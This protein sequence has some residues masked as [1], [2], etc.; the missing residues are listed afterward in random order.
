M[1]AAGKKILGLSAFYHDSAAALLREGRIERAAQEE[2]FSRKKHDP[3]FPLNAIKFCLAGSGP[4][5]LRGADSP[6]T[7]FSALLRGISCIVFYEKPFLTFE[8]LLESYLRYAPRQGFAS[9]REAM[10]L[11]MGKKLNMRALIKRE[12]KKRPG[13]L[14]K[15]HP[16]DFVQLSSSFPCRLRF[17][18]QRLSKGGDTLSGRG[19]GDGHKLRLAWRGESNSSP[20]AD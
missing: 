7:D 12:L 8:R 4:Q 1:G 5:L 19:G 15:R 6:A 3:S 17:F 11:W 14:I 18:S 9:F 10:P 13:L 2:R 20:L 16:G